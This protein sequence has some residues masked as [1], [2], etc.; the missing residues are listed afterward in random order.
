MQEAQTNLKQAAVD[1]LEA[2]EQA[3]ARA[4]QSG[5]TD[6][7][8]GVSTDLFELGDLEPAIGPQEID[9]LRRRLKTETLVPQAI[10]E[11]IGLARQVAG[12]LGA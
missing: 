6:P 1:F 3:A 7:L 10:I 9:A 11:L 12:A 8:D 5:A 4:G 2:A